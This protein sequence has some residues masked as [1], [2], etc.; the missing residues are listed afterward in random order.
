M[1]FLTWTPDLARRFWDDLAG[2]DFLAEL[3]FSRFAAPYLVELCQEYLARQTVALDFGGGFNAYLTKE[4]LRT[5]V[6]V[7]LY[8]PS[9]R[10]TQLPDDIRGNPRFLGTD[11]TI[12]PNEYDVIFAVEVIEH[13][14]DE[15]VAAVLG[16][17]YEGLK[18]G[19]VL[20]MTTPNQEDLRLSSRYCP[21]CRHLFHPWG[22]LRSFDKDS[23]RTLLNASGFEC[24]AVWNVD[25]SGTRES[26]EE[27]KALKK[28]VVAQAEEAEAVLRTAWLLP[29]RA[30]RLL[31]AVAGWK[32]IG[33]SDEFRV[34]PSDRQIGAGGTLVAFAR[35]M[36]SG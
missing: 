13:V 34:D 14:F 28:A 10:E 19:G 35:R 31:K 2:T 33:R 8:E 12:T 25:F 30:R 5:G 26:L 23:L 16:K 15:G 17:I 29:G 3:T 4:L 11:P 24:E 36:Q 32:R 27:L 20:V 6:S 22:H 1:R 18:V 7:R 9:L 21:T